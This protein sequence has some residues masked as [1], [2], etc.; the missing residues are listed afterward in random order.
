MLAVQVM[1]PPRRK[2]RSARQSQRQIAAIRSNRQMRVSP[3]PA[4]RTPCAARPPAAALWTSRAPG[5]TY[6]SAAA[7]NRWFALSRTP[8]EPPVRQLQPVPP[9]FPHVM[10]ES[11]RTR[12][13][14][15]RRA[16]LE[17]RGGACG[18][19]GAGA[20]VNDEHAPSQPMRGQPPRTGWLPQ[21]FPCPKER[22]TPHQTGRHLQLLPDPTY[23]PGRKTRLLMRN[24]T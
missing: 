22:D 14:A 10:W 24:G 18:R 23:C 2:R 5:A 4:R 20:R 21:S 16:P 12:P 1:E 13:A 3:V 15:R 19:P 11:V 7:L 6:P 8:V 9:G 17:F